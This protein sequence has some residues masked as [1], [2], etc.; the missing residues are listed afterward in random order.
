MKKLTF[1]FSLVKYRMS[2]I[3]SELILLKARLAA[4]EEQK[5][6]EAEKDAEKKENPMKVLETI[7]EDKKKRPNY[8]AGASRGQYGRPNNPNIH[9]GTEDKEW[10]IDQNDKVEF[11]EP[12]FNMLKK[13]EERLDIL[14]NKKKDDSIENL[15]F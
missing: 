6:I 5:R 14:E 9:L 2:T 3:D 15:V 4:L 13:I 12:I 10:V 11:L 8:L 7:L 1:S